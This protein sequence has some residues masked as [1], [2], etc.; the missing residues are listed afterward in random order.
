MG[1]EQSITDSTTIYADSIIIIVGFLWQ[2]LNICSS[3]RLAKRQKSVFNSV[4]TYCQ[5]LYSL[6]FLIQGIKAWIMLTNGNYV[7]FFTPG[8]LS[9]LDPVSQL[10]LILAK[11]QSCVF[12]TSTFI[13]KFQYSNIFYIIDNNVNNID[14][15]SVQY[16]FKNFN[17]F[18][19]HSSIWGTVLASITIIFYLIG[20]FT[21]IFL[22]NR[23]GCIQL[24]MVVSIWFS[25]IIIVEQTIS[26]PTLIRLYTV[27]NYIQT[28]QMTY[29]NY[30]VY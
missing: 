17:K 29:S 15:L 23:I 19:G 9:P 30:H 22:Y 25:F 8:T 18:F 14:T 2:S 16:R 26:R 24:D 6:V 1:Y 5:A 21:S 11:V 20:S 28:F 12:F 3:Y 13:C 27:Y 4:V 10:I 7:H